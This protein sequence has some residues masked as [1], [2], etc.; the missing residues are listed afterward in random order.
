LPLAILPLRAATSLLFALAWLACGGPRP[1][2]TS[3]PLAEW[4]EYGGDKGGLRYS[5]LTQITR[6][7]V[8]DLELAWVHHH[9]D[10]SDGT[11]EVTRTSFNATPIAIGDSLY[12]CTGLNRVIALDAETGALR[13]SFDPQLR[14]RRLQ[15][16]YP[17]TCRG[18]AHWEDPRA[19]DDA[20]CRERIFT[21]TIDA[22]LIAVDARSGEPCHAPTRR[23]ILQPAPLRLSKRSRVRKPVTRFSCGRG[24]LLRCHAT[25]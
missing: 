21:A 11:Q 8:G 25:P 20:A 18:V 5:P 19:R 1:L 17:L 16:P 13:W 9:G 24:S 23:A 6:E 7:N 14:G 3:G 12:F 4:P 15:G 2:D 10:V 22:E